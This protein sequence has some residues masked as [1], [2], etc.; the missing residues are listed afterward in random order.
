MALDIWRPLQRDWNRP[1][2]NLELRLDLSIPAVD[3]ELI[4]ISWIQAMLSQREHDCIEVIDRLIPWI[5]AAL[6]LFGAKDKL[7][8]LDDSDCPIMC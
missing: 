1:T 5:V 3:D 4:N 8:V 6:L 2:E 7:S